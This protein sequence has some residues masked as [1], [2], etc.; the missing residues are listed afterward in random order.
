MFISCSNLSVVATDFP[1]FSIAFYSFETS[2]SATEITNNSIYVYPTSLEVM[3]VIRPV[4][5]T[6]VFSVIEF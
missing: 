3:S 2:F 6:L 1:T 4:S 5:V